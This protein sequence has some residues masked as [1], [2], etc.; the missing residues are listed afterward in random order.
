MIKKV[1]LIYP[2]FSMAERYG[3]GLEAIGTC[4][5]PLGLLSLAAVLEE[6]SYEVKVYDSDLLN[7][8]VGEMVDFV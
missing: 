4:L 7:S 6:S 3:A 1:I 2:P 8:A 5:P